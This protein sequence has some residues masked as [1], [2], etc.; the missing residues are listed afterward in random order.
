VIAAR[1]VVVALAASMLFSLSRLACATTHVP[2]AADVDAVATL[3]A[4]DATARDAVTLLPPWSMSIWPALSGTPHIVRI[5]GDRLDDALLQRHDR[6][7]VVVEPDGEDELAAVIAKWGSPDATTRVGRLDVVRFDIARHHGLA[8]FDFAPERRWIAATENGTQ[9]VI[10]PTSTSFPFSSVPLG[11]RLQVR[12]GHTRRGVEHGKADVT[13]SV[14]VDD[15]LVSQVTKRPKFVAVNQR[16]WLARLFARDT[17]V[18]QGFTT[19]SI[20]TEPH[21]GSVRFEITTT[22]ADKNEVAFDALAIP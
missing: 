9:A 7:F 3:L 21:V 14:F 5:S 6:V 16:R 8:L 17:D 22:N 4:S 13:L 2:A 20:V 18:D 11:S 1:V 15:V 12:F 10:A 19:T